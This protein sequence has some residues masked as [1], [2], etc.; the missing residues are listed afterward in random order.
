M[1]KLI[2]LL[3]I[4]FPFLH[5][6]CLGAELVG[7][8]VLNA[9]TFSPGS[10]TAQFKTTSRKTPF[11]YAQPVQG[12]SAVVSG[13]KPGT[14]FVL[15]DNGFGSKVN[16]P[17]YALR[18]YALEPDFT[19]GKVFPVNFKTGE[20]LNNFNRQSFLELNDINRKVNF[21]IVADET[22]YPGSNIQVSQ[23]IKEKRLLTG[24]DFDTESFR[25]VSDGT[26]WLGD[27]FGPFLLHVGANGEL[28]SAPIPTP[29]FQKIGNFNFIQSV[30]NPEFANLPQ[31]DKLNRANLGGSKGFEGMALNASGTKLYPI[32]EGA[33]VGDNKQNRLSIYEFDLQNK[34]YTGKLFYYKLEKPEHAIG[35]LTAINNKEFIVIERDVNQGDP[36]NSAFKNPAQFKRL[37]KINL[38]KVDN[39]G[40]VEKELL[41]DLLNISDLT[42]VGGSATKNGIFTFPFVT[43]ESVLPLDERTLL[44]IND[45]NYADSIGRTPGQV[46]NTEFIKIR[47]DKP[48]AIRN[49]QFATPHSQLPTPHSPLIDSWQVK[50]KL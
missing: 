37:Y 7:R 8:A 4:A 18:I 5:S 13:P 25:R 47:L 40:F 29:N 6:N 38:Q 39:E 45:N 19:T 46:D 1:I 14:Y 9:D 3:V 23:V 50:Y 21:P 24:G 30:D 33:I 32:L 15:S 20:R 28:L 41:V 48:L 22:V 42:G 49:S 35:E 2:F 36:R 31:S 12:F 16:S 44:I 26:F 27:E 11:F 43:I 34:S 17:D 10:T